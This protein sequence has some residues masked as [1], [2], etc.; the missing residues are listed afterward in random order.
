[1][2]SVVV[3]VYRSAPLLPALAER[4]KRVLEAEQRPWEIVMVDEVAR[5]N[6]ARWEALAAANAP[7]SR[8]LLDLD[9]ASA[10]EFID[11][12]GL[13]GAIAGRDVL[14]LAGGGGKQ[15]VAF[16]LLG[17]WVTVAD[18][19]EAQLARDRAAAARNPACPA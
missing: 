13:L 16:A 3:P 11:P 1:M 10:R 8:P 15:S 19:S 18:L 17:A 7:F 9:A 12:E 4:L 6:I 2:I 5:Y 14:C